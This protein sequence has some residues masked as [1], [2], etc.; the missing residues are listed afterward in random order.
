[1]MEVVDATALDW[2]LFNG[3]KFFFFFKYIIFQIYRVCFLMIVL[4]Y[5][6]KTPIGP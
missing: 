6:I 5:H 1:M 4:Y 2:A 3:Y